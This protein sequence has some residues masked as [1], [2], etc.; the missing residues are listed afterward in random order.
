[1]AH[2]GTEKG[3]KARVSFLLE[4]KKKPAPLKTAATLY[5][6]LHSC[7][8][9]N[10]SPFVSRKKHVGKGTIVSEKQ[11]RKKCAAC[12]A[13]LILGGFGFDLI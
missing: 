4:K 13:T 8:S 7:F 1:M 10:C 11:A 6:Y 5:F 9:L 12:P 3:K 2:R